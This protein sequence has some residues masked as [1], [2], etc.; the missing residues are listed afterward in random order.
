MDSWNKNRCNTHNALQ[1]N[2][3]K[4]KQNIFFK[5]SNFYD[6]ILGFIL[7]FSLWIVV[8]RKKYFTNLANPKNQNLNLDC[9][10]Y[11]C[12][13]RLIVIVLTLG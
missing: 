11:A 1:N 4:L 8:W 5:L 12:E 13:I 2:G 7:Y 3:S 9:T 10:D 6:Y